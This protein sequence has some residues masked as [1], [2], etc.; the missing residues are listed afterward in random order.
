MGAYQIAIVIGTIY[1]TN[2]L[3]LPR[4]AGSPRTRFL[5][6]VLSDLFILVIR[7]SKH[8]YALNRNRDL[9]LIP[10]KIP[11]NKIGAPMKN[12]RVSTGG[13]TLRILRN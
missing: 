6:K 13:A 8:I 5:Y 11:L 4:L 7:N 1:I 2:I 3:V 9:L 10:L 12:S